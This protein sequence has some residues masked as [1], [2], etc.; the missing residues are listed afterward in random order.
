MFT[1]P[2][3]AAWQPLFVFY[4]YLV[5]KKMKYSILF[6]L[7]PVFCA[8]QP[9]SYEDSL[10]LYIKKYV[11]SHEVVKGADKQMMQFYKVDKSWRVKALFKKTEGST[12]FMMPTSGKIKKEFRLYGTLSF[13]LHDTAVV[14]HVYQSRQLMTL[15]AYA[16]YLFI[17]F[18]DATTGMDTY[19]GGRYMDI[20]L[21]DIQSGHCIIDFNK[22]YNPYCAYAA[23]YNCPVPP[24]ENDLPVAVLA[25]EKNYAL[26]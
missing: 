4:H 12:W 23:G 3:A 20:V 9:K 25:G 22:A 26:H 2:R 16:D 18:T 15:P 19:G 7:F 21:S 13:L 14:L 1:K 8:A 10:N 6:M 24:K 5:R 11:D 17:P